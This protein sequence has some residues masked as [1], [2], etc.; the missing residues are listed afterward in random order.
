MQQYLNEIQIS[1]TTCLLAIDFS[2]M[3]ITFH[4]NIEHTRTYTHWRQQEYHDF[5]CSSHHHY[6]DTSG[7]HDRDTMTV[8]LELIR[9]PNMMGINQK[10]DKSS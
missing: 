4:E 1:N 6:H 10:M 3:H 9:R 7:Y 5:R 8:P 2:G